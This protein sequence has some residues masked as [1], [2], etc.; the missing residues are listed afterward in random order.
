MCGHSPQPPHQAFGIFFDPLPLPCLG[1]KMGGN[2]RNL[3]RLDMKLCSDKTSTTVAYPGEE[4][5]IFVSR[6]CQGPA[7]PHRPDAVKM[8]GGAHSGP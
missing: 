8:L 4:E 5:Q 3:F 6:R 7:C 2:M 1:K